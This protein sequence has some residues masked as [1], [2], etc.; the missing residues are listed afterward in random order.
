MFSTPL[1]ITNKN[2]AREV[3]AQASVV[4]A[5]ENFSILTETSRKNTAP[6]IIGTAVYWK[7]YDQGNQ[8]LLFLPS[9]HYIPNKEAFEKAINKG[10]SSL[11]KHPDCIICFGIKPRIAHTGYGYIQKGK[12]N[13]ILSFTEKPNKKRAKKYIASGQYLWNSGIF[14]CTSGT[15]INEAKKYCPDILNGVQADRDNKRIINDKTTSL[16]FDIAIMEKSRN[17]KVI[18]TDFIWS[19]LGSWKQLTVYL[20]NKLFKKDVSYNP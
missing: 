7:K 15:L 13:T 18:E 19:D 6:A 12:D 20:Y 17:T 14:L 4:T 10:L 2:Q 11:K 3:H 5:G 9:D 1:F 8:P 16:S